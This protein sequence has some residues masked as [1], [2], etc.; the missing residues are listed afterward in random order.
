MRRSWD[1]E[2][3]E[4]HADQEGRQEDWSTNRARWATRTARRSQE[5]ECDHMIARDRP[6]SWSS[7][8]ITPAMTVTQ[9]DPQAETES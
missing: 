4:R 2:N 7:V 5:D 1:R 3:H 9:R 6:S 8:Q